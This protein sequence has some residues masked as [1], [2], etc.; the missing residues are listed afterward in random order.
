MDRA[1]SESRAGQVDADCPDASRTTEVADVSFQAFLES[2]APP[3]VQWATAEGFEVVAAGVAARTEPAGDDPPEERFS[4]TRRRA[5]DV[6]GELD[7]AGPDVARPRSFGGFSFFPEHEPE[8]PWTGF[9]PASFVVPAVQL[10]RAADTTWLTIVADDAAGVEERLAAE[11]DA[12]ADLPAMQPTGGPPGV[13]ATDHVTPRLDWT[14]QVADA[15][16]RIRADGLRKVVL[17]TALDVDLDDAIRPPS[18]LERLRRTY[19]DCYRFLVQP[20]DGAAFFGAPPERLVKLDGRTVETEALAG[21]VERGD[22]PEK[23]ASLANSLLESDKLQEEQGL[24]VDAIREALAPLGEVTVGDQTVRKLTNIQHLQTPIA[25]TLDEDA[26]VLSVVEALHPTPAVGGVPRGMA[27]DLIRETESFERGWYAAPVGWFDADGD[28]E[29][30]V[31]IRSGVAGGDWT[32]LFAG[33]GIV[34]DSDPDEEWAE[35]APKFRP[36]LDELDPGEP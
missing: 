4:A 23:D 26:H 7:H 8:P 3:R 15:V 19:P 33:N 9:T 30:T 1:G 31:G 5:A 13:A 27:L 29:F 35:I 22:T 34:A 20:R 18:V 21:S 6:F 12:L 10:T 28:G 36:I 2:R 32:T 17:A 11:T 14:T 24:V 25:A 16:E